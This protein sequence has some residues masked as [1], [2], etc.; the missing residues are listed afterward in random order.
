MMFQEPF[1]RI[2]YHPPERLGF[3]RSPWRAYRYRHSTCWSAIGPGE[4]RGAY[5]SSFMAS[6][7]PASSGAKRL[8]CGQ[9]RW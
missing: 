2:R 6:S 1:T 5:P 4:R 8:G 7:H 9:L 3:D